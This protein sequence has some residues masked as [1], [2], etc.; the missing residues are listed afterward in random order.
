MTKLA[1]TLALSAAATASAF[2]AP[3]QAQ[4]SDQWITRAVREVYSRAPQSAECNINRYGGGQWGSY[5]QLKR[6][7]QLQY[8]CSDPWIGQ[9]VSEAFGRPPR[10]SGSSGECNKYLYTAAWSN[11]P[12]LKTRVQVA[13][14]ALGG[15]S[16]G[17]T[18]SG[19]MTVGGSALPLDIIKIVTPA[20]MVAAGGGNLVGNNGNTLVG[21]DGA[22][23]VGADG[24]T[25]K[26]YGLQSTARVYRIPGGSRIIVP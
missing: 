16:I 8:A 20:G 17:F 19:Q 22:S 9:A 21:P 4:C 26:R 12:D 13:L 6:Y 14:T 24:A 10:G 11:Y 3:A 18:G 2:A 25:L 15:M 23:L 5:D 7:V 1:W